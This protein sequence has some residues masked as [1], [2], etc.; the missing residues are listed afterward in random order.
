MSAGPP[1]LFCPYRV[2][3]VSKISLCTEAHGYISAIAACPY[4]TYLISGAC[5]GYAAGTNATVDPPTLPLTEVRTVAAFSPGER[6]LAC[7]EQA[8]HMVVCMYACK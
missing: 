3:Y 8:S 7:A 1:L 5:S 6:V 4:G 2:I